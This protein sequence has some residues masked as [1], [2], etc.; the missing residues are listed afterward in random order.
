[1]QSELVQILSLTLVAFTFGM[2]VPQLLIVLPFGIWTNICA[3]QW[4][5]HFAWLTDSNIP[6]GEALAHQILVQQ[7]L[8][9]FHVCIKILMSV[10][11]VF[12]FVD[13]E[14]GGTIICFVHLTDSYGLCSR[15]LCVV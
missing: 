14:F 8:Y 7:P 11:C 12:V 15:T 5:K 4:V 13:Y 6:F 1:M 9:E 3:Y 2:L 10:V